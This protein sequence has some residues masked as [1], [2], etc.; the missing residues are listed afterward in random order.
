[1][2]RLLY[3][4]LFIVGAYSSR[5]V[6]AQVGP[7]PC[8]AVSS[9]TTWR[10]D[11]PY[12]IGQ[13]VIFDG[14]TYQS[15]TN[16]NINQNPCTYSGT[17]WNNVISGGGGGGSPTGP[18][19]GILAG[20]YPNPILAQSGSLPNGW[21]A[22]TQAMGDTSKNVATDEFVIA[23]QSVSAVTSIFTRVGTVVAQTGDY[24]VSQITG[25]APMSSP[26]F[27]G[28][29]TLPITGTT[30]C[31]HVNSAGVVT[32][33]GG[34]CGSGSSGVS[35]FNTRT[36]P[37][38]PANGDYT[39]SQVTGAA[40]LAS[41]TLTGTP[42]AP[43]KPISD[44]NTEL[45]TTGAVNSALGVYALLASPAFTGVPTAPTAA[46]GTDTTQLATTQFAYN[47]FLFTGGNYNSTQS[48]QTPTYFPSIGSII[49]VDGFPS[50][51]GTYA[52]TWSSSTAYS[53]FQTVASGG[54]I[55][56][57]VNGSTNVTPAAGAAGSA[58]FWAPC[59]TG[60]TSVVATQADAAFYW[61]WGQVQVNATGFG[62][63][64]SVGLVFGNKLGGYNKNC[65]W[66]MPTNSF[67]YTISMFG[68]GRNQT[69]VHQTTSTLN[70][71][72]SSPQVASSGGQTIQGMT[73]D[74]NV[75]AGGCLTHHLRR[76]VI[77]DI[78]CWNPQQQNTGTIGAAMWL[79][80]A[81]D[82]FETK[83]EHL[84]VRGQTYNGIL[85]AYGTA[86][87][88]SGSI[89]GITWTSTGTNLNL[90]VTAGPGLVAYF[91][92]TGSSYKPCGTNPAVSAIAL[93]GGA[94]NTGSGVGGFTFSNA[95][96][97]CS[98]TVYVRV[99]QAGTLNEAYY[100]NGSDTTADD[101]VTSGDFNVACEYVNGPFALTHEHPYCAAPYQI[102][103]DG[104]GTRNH[105][106]PELDS[107]IEYGMYIK[108][109]GANVF[110]GFD[111]YNS[112]GTTAGVNDYLID[113]SATNFSVNNSGCYSGSVQNDGGYNKYVSTSSGP[114]SST[115]TAWPASASISGIQENCDGTASLWGT[116]PS[117]NNGIPTLYSGS[118]TY[119]A[120]AIA[121]DG[122]GNNYSSLSSGNVGNALTNVT[123]WHFLGGI[124]ATITGGNCANA[125]DMNG[126][127][128]AGVPSC[129][130]PFTITASS[131]PA[132]TLANGPLQTITLTS[133]ATPTITG[134]AGSSRLVLQICQG[135]TVYNWT[136]PAAIHGGICI[137]T[138]CAPPSLPNTCSTQPFVSY[139]GS[140]LVP[141]S[142][143]VANVAP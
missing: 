57:A 20:N 77:S 134:I 97:T 131:T 55:W 100:F 78:A 83:Y 67:G 39:V 12:S 21:V 41:P 60:S 62:A 104:N 9:I 38:V 80:Q 16:N 86:T 59:A 109:S 45:A 106:G 33:T 105:F 89:T 69:W 71:M 6:H 115:S 34:D 143:G 46:N 1:M 130:S 29:V 136:W 61:A 96:A 114:L 4:L 63:D 116:Y 42:L 65:D 10:N 8:G 51:G 107:P 68:Q 14:V 23:N 133:A 101:I 127:S 31:L 118:V 64:S 36:G 53:R 44:N 140:T 40:P 121:Y 94:I 11:F 22:V 98:G 5:A 35:S 91:T 93:T 32:G 88:T 58:Q 15:I 110:G 37:V 108:G 139:T 138:S 82:A 2:K 43:T 66:V 18:A 84:L 79:G 120:G 74:A 48:T 123:F 128:T 50:G 117:F 142:V 13:V 122:S 125:V 72:V 75:L 92:G 3:I 81:A 24:T 132:I 137:G 47:N 70:F 30:Q 26:T 27:T 113:G 56:I 25:A 76:S 85:P 17:Q 124:S 19:G 95:G 112:S 87:L 129:N 90:P 54:T 103:S 7:L 73:L 102:Y 141:E 135:A 119:A 111:E 52:G 49:Q 126:I 28:T 99:Q